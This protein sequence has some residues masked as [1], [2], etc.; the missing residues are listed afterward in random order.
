MPGLAL[1]DLVPAVPEV[2]LVVPEVPLVVPEVPL[3]VPEFGPF[4]GEPDAGELVV[5][6]PVLADPGDDA[7]VAGWSVVLGV[8]AGP[9]LAV[10]LTPT[11]NLPP[12][13]L[14]VA[15]AEA[16]S[17]AVPG[18]VT[19]AVVAVLAGAFV[20]AVLVG[21]GVVGVVVGVAVGLGGELTGTAVGVTELR[22]VAAGEEVVAAAGDEVVGHAVTFG[23]LAL[24]VRRC[25]LT[26]PFGEL[27]R[28]VEAAPFRLGVPL[29]LP[30]EMPATWPASWPSWTRA[31]RV[32][33]SARATPMANTAHATASAGRSRP[34]RQS[35]G[36]RRAVSGWGPVLSRPPI[37]RRVSPTRKPPASP[38]RECLLA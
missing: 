6:G 25:G 10:P 11:I 35:R 26:V 32:G 17:P 8:L 13:A 12:I 22:G 31:S 29:A 14:R 2:P 18:G 7:V 16:V 28:G 27:P 3:V 36:W 5:A 21:V 38:A 33:G 1:L 4:V 34:S 24:L 30:V 37:Q 15:F 23:L 20:V 9:Q 19:V